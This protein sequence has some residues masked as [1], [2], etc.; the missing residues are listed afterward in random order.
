[1]KDVLVISDVMFNGAYLTPGR[2]FL[3]M[4]NNEEVVHLWRIIRILVAQN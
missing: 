3:K 4:N 2:G 1:M